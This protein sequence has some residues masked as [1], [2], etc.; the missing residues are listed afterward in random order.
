MLRYKNKD[1]VKKW[2]QLVKIKGDVELLKYFY[3][4]NNLFTVVFYGKNEE[5]I[6]A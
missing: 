1:Q 6:N 2:P 3:F 4:L 5:G